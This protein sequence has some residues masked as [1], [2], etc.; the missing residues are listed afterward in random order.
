MITQMWAENTLI[1][2]K[3]HWAIEGDAPI[4]QAL[5]RGPIDRYSELVAYL[6]P[7]TTIY[8]DKPQ[9]KGIYQYTL[10]HFDTKG[11][12]ISTRK[13]VIDTHS[14]I[15]T[16]NESL[17]NADQAF[18]DLEKRLNERITRQAE[19]LLALNKRLARL[20]RR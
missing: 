13:V 3:L 10:D 12:I 17:A 2:V 5:R 19:A 4:F 11:K 16:F 15:P 8:V 9:M 20:E 18:G 1:G 6:G 7:K 14:R